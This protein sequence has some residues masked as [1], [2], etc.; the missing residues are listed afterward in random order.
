MLAV[1]V[2]SSHDS[3]RELAGVYEAR[4]IVAFGGRVGGEGR[5]H[6]QPRRTA[7]H[8]LEIRECSGVVLRE[9]ASK[10]AHTAFA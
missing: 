2:V 4:A 6:P 3:G 5:Q 10:Q 8:S 9:Q 1:L 7:K